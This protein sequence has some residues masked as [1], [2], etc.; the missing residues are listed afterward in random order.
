M[1]GYNTD[2]LHGLVFGV[3]Y[4]LVLKIR[5]HKQCHINT[6]RMARVHVCCGITVTCSP[7]YNH[8]GL[9]TEGQPSCMCSVSHTLSCTCKKPAQCSCELPHVAWSSSVYCLSP[10]HDQPQL[11]GG[12]NSGAGSSI[13]PHFHLN[14][15]PS[16]HVPP[17]LPSLEGWAAHCCSLRRVSSWPCQCLCNCHAVQGTAAAAPQWVLAVSSH[18]VSLLRVAKLDIVSHPVRAWNIGS[19]QAFP[20]PRLGSSCYFVRC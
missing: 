11:V 5:V 1:S 6:F 18:A 10:V 2:R 20:R 15:L 7:I 8:R 19:A 13:W 3:R 12:G 16:L 17:E 9:C 14:T 4:I